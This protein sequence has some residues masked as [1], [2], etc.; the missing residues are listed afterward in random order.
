MT[1]ETPTKQEQIARFL[2]E[3]CSF[4]RCRYWLGQWQEWPPIAEERPTPEELAEEL[5]SFS[6]F[7]ALQLGTWLRTTDGEII[8][9]ALE[10]VAPPFYRQDIELLFAA[11]RLAASI[12]QS[13]GQDKA[14]WVGLAGL[15]AA[16]GIGAA[17]TGRA[18]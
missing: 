15:V 13:E 16:A 6:E 9:A 7:R 5:L 14:V 3:R 2:M 8:S 18:A 10:M 1:Q 4:P 17:I 11:L 12:Q